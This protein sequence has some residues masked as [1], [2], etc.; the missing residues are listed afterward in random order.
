MVPKSELMFCR[1]Y[2]K[3]FSVQ[4]DFL[5]RIECK[6]S[7]TFV[8][9]EKN[10]PPKATTLCF[11][12]RIPRTYFGQTT[13]SVVA[14]AKSK[15]LNCILSDFKERTSGLKHQ[16]KGFEVSHKTQTEESLDKNLKLL[17]TFLPD[18]NLTL[19]KLEYADFISSS[20]G[21]EFTSILDKL[22]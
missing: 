12:L 7:D 19:T 13:D 22:K 6:I 10:K 14:A 11:D 15:Y 5:G 8:F 1:R 17:K 3:L 18:L 16:I 4:K 2:Q 20:K 21:V 9:H